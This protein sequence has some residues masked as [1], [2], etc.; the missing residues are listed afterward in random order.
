MADKKAIKYIVPAA[1]VVTAAVTGINGEFSAAKALIPEVSP[2]YAQ[3]ASDTKTKKAGGV[4]VKKQALSGNKT[5]TGG[6]SSGG[7]RTVNHDS[8]LDGQTYKDGVYTGNGRGYNG[9]LTVQVTILKGKVFKAVLVANQ[10]D[11]LPYLN[12][13]KAVLS[14]IVR[15]QNTKVDAVSGATYSSVGLITAVENALKKAI[16]NKSGDDDGTTPAKK[17]SKRPK[18]PMAPTAPETEDEPYEGEGL[19]V[20]GE[21]TGFARGYKGFLYVTVTIKNEKISAIEITKTGDDE[22]YLTS[23]KTLIKRIIAKQTTEG[24]DAVSGATYSSNGI[25]G[26]V[27]K[28]LDKAKKP[29]KE[30]T[31]PTDTTEQ[32]PSDEPATEPPKEP[33][34]D[35]TEESSGEKDDDSIGEST[36]KPSADDEA[37]ADNQQAPTTESRQDGESR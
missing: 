1:L 2:A 8:S 11:D 10:G 15:T 18:T 21:Y 36:D 29:E 12:R 37:D 9:I 16:I 17:P 5:T 31:E 22:P 14:A 30:E 19:Y 3:A 4:K 33:E 13:A 25:L 28:A 24:I 32:T 26:A 35:P 6:A 27:Q 20:D 34:P 7:S 23:A